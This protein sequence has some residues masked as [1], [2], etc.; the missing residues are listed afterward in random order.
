MSRL[1]IPGSQFDIPSEIRER[2]AQI[3]PRLHVRRIQSAYN[4]STDGGDFSRLVE[5]WI[6]CLSWMENDPRRA[7]TNPD[8]CFDYLGDVPVD[9]PIEQMPGALSRI[10][11]RNTLAPREV[12]EQVLKWNEDQKLRNGNIEYYTEEVLDRVRTAR[13]R[14]K[15]T[16]EIPD[17]LSDE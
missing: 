14:G 3:D 12:V 16:V 11:H 6:V 17:P 5:K 8:H 15:K 2:I 10:L 13:K 4:D 7:A 9:C 1:A